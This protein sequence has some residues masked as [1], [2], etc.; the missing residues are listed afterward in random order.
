M[1]VQ[2]NFG[3]ATSAT[4]NG[5]ILDSGAGF[6]DGRGY[7]WVTESSLGSGNP[8]PIDISVNARDRD[9]ISN[10]LR[11]TLIHLQYPDDI[12]NNSA[13]RTPAAWEYALANGTYRVRV[14]VGDPVFSDSRH[15]INLEGVNVISDFV[16]TGNQLFTEATQLIQVND[17]RLTL[18]AIGGENTKVNF[19][20][21][22]SVTS[23]RINFGSS[24]GFVPGYIHDNGQG[25]SE[26]RGYGFVTQDS[27]GSADPTPIDLS[28]NVRTRGN[29]SDPLLNSLI[30]LQYAPNVSNPAA[31]RT[32]AAWEYDLPD[33]TYRVTVS[34]G[35]STFTD[36]T[37]VINAEGVNLISGFTPTGDT[38][39]T[40]ASQVVQVNDGRLTIDAIGGTN[41]K[42]NYIEIEPS[43]ETPV[44]PG[45]SEIRFNFGTADGAFP[46]GYIQDVGEGYNA[47]T[48]F[49]WIRQDSVGSDNPTP[50][51]LVANG[52]DRQLVDDDTLNT[53]IH[54]Q[55]PTGINNPDA[56]TTPGAWEYAIAD[57]LYRVTVG[58]GDAAFIDS[59]HVI[60][61]EGV[62]LI[63]GFTPNNDQKFTTGTQVVEVND[64]R[65]TIDAIGGENTKINFVEIEA[66]DSTTNSDGI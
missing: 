13:V 5:Y 9:I 12:E 18:D 1:L 46:E 34:V 30:H 54:M 33:G 14:S 59:T 53:L 42:I 55:Y 60:N 7:G 48:G 40:E 6:N 66:V 4:P 16:P 19:I 49:G 35:D 58:V 29:E 23:A 28:A 56:V 15:V 27:A 64:G 10:Q 37:H 51:D 61:A 32:P 65:L 26:A 20:E 50:L 41:T 38:R 45:N 44:S 62:N 52:R 8:T 3:R 22:E 21:I 17:G 31:V 24:N 11:D 2:I 25:Y 39:F 57:G 63:S 36:S 43:T 47:E